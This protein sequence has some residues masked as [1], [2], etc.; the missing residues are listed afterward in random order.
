[1]RETLLHSTYRMI[2]LM[3]LCWW[4]RAKS[5]L[6]ACQSNTL[7][8]NGLL[9]RVVCK[10]NYIDVQY[11]Y[12]KMNYMRYFLDRYFV[13]NLECKIVFNDYFFIIIRCQVVGFHY[14]LISAK[15]LITPGAHPWFTFARLL[16]VLF[17]MQL[18]IT[19]LTLLRHN[20]YFFVYCYVIMFTF[21]VYCYVTMFTSYPLLRH[22]A[23]ILSIV[24]S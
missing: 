21:F 12:F 2:F 1:M 19:N 20:V 9:K 11:F 24:T 16:S 18:I 17:L 13:L 4:R 3:W 7:L 15:S 5:F 22:N 8:F 10:Y 6:K 23:Y 14:Q